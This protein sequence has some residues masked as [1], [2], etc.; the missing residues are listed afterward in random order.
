M[1]GTERD[2]IGVK[3]EAS[4]TDSLSVRGLAMIMKS[5]GAIN[6]MKHFFFQLQV[7]CISS[8][9]VALV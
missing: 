4:K 9:Q 1:S 7:Y 5:A 2:R 8:K 6:P 3:N